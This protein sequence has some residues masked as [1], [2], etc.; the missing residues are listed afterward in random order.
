MANKHTTLVSLFDDIADAI[1]ELLGTSSNI[2]A[3]TFPDK[4]REI[5]PCKLKDKY[6]IAIP[7]VSTATINQVFTPKCFYHI[8]SYWFIGGENSSHDG[9]VAFS[10]DRVNWTIQLIGPGAERKMPVNA[11]AYYPASDTLY[12]FGNSNSYKSRCI[13]YSSNFISNYVPSNYNYFTSS[14]DNN[15]MSAVQSDHYAWAVRG[16]NATW[17]MNLSTNVGGI[18]THG[19]I[20]HGY[21]KNCMYKTYPIAISSDGYYTYKTSISKTSVSSEFQIASGFTSAVCAQMGDYLVIAGTKSDGTY[22]YYSNGTPGSMTFTAGKILSAQV[23]PI[24][25]AYANGLYVMAYMENNVLRFYATESLGNAC[26]ITNLM[27]TAIKNNTG[28]ALIANGNDMAVLTGAGG[29]P[30]IGYYTVL[31][32]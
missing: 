22:L 1:R 10:T 31:S 32:E 8:G 7:N 17:Y 16:D 4:L 27:A 19:S 9:Y 14:G 13:I 24:G 28:V 18:Y 5:M 25:L 23:T 11:L 6:N 12:V 26:G 2:V 3:D 21:I 15:I 20:S 30:A 29:K